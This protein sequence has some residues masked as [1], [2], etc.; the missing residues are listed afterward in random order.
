MDQQRESLQIVLSER[1]TTAIIPGQTFKQVRVP[2]PTEADLQDGQLLLESLYLAIDAAMRFWAEDKR[3]FMPPVQ[4]GE[5]M[6]GIAVVRVLASR[7]VRAKAGD[8]V[9][10]MLGFQEVGILP[11]EAV[12][13]VLP[14][15]LPE[16]AKY[17]YTDYIGLFNWSG[18]SGYFGMSKIGEPKPGETVLVSG[19]A[20]AT[21]SIAAQV[22]K[23][24][25]AR[26]I[27]TAGSDEKVRWLKEELGLDVAL[28]YKDPDFEQKLAEATPD[29]IDVFYDTVGGEI[30]NQALLRARPHAR[31]VI[32]GQISQY[33]AKKRQGPDGQAFLS[34]FTQRVKMQGFIVTDWGN[35]FPE[36]IAKL[37]Q[38]VNEGKIK[39]KE[40]LVT[41]GLAVAE[42]ALSYLF[43]GKSFG[44]VIVQVKDINA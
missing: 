21:G 39:R 17:T 36:A 18:L 20:G 23:I 9:T 35:E 15:P 43:N 4:V 8:I 10:A 22:A 5:V 27:G 38:W 24:A 32:C 6:R 29:W 14:S 33:N 37:G 19:A 30:L 3:S 44:K 41:G 1:P 26:V 2:A 7:S 42:E 28:N 16:G 13:S 34:V 31:F 25:G 40:T 11:E 12:V